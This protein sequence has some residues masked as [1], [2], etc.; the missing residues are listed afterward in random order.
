MTVPANDNRNVCVEVK[1]VE[2]GAQERVET[3]LSCN[4]DDCRQKVDLYSNG[5]DTVHTIYCPVHGEIGFFQNYA[6]FQAFTKFAVDKI[7]EAH[8]QDL[9]SDKTKRLQGKGESGKAK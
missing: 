2:D 3:A 6:A 4:I 1:V 5:P 7:L 9:I 8:E